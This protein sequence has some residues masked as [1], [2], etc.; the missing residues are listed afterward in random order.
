MITRSRFIAPAPATF[1]TEA[2][3]IYSQL[4]AYTWLACGARL[5]CDVNKYQ[6][7]GMYV[8]PLVDGQ[9]RHSRHLRHKD[10]VN[11]N[12]LFHCNQSQPTGA[13]SG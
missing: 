6:T 11:R 13:E 7:V 10:L 8:S 5:G 2:F 3:K 1:I 9:H 12:P 4:R